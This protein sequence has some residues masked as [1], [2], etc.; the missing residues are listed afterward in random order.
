MI[1][2]ADVKDAFDRLERVGFRMPASWP[3]NPAAA[4]QAIRDW[5]RA[6]SDMTKERFDDAVSRFIAEAEGRWWPVP[7]Q[8]RAKAADDML[9]GMERGM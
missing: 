4:R 9:A 6:L 8:I 1:T 5:R 2:N 3:V 7:G